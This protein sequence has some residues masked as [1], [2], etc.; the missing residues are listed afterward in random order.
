MSLLTKR[1]QVLA[2]LICVALVTLVS[3]FFLSLGAGDEAR[4][5]FAGLV[6]LSDWHSSQL[7]TETLR[8][9][10][11]LDQYILETKV[12]NEPILYSA[13]KFSGAASRQFWMIKNSLHILS[14]GDEVLQALFQKL[15]NLES[16]ISRVS[17]DNKE[18]NEQVRAIL[19]DLDAELRKYFQTVVTGEALEA[20][21]LQDL[22]ATNLRNELYILGILPQACSSR[23]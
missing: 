18:V 10:G 2:F 6:R 23:G 13:M 12:S 7:H 17:R 20:I 22:K 1:F 3:S 19:L 5:R 4:Q 14:N 16:V 15:K 11:T 9:I 21:W 8:L